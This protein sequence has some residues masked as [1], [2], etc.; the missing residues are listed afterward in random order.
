MV[1]TG[2]MHVQNSKMHAAVHITLATARP[3]AARNL[4]MWRVQVSTG[5]GVWRLKWHPS[6][7]TRLLAACMHNGFAGESLA[8][9]LP[10]PYNC[11]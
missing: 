5:G 8:D 10:H 4:E 2:Q 9:V 1:T 7:A 11:L 3:S 6:H